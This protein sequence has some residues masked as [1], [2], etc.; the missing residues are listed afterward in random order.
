VEKPEELAAVVEPFTAKPTWASA[1][2]SSGLQSPVEEL[3]H[4]FA[5]V[6]QLLAA[7]HEPSPDVATKL[8]HQ[9]TTWAMSSQQMQAAFPDSSRT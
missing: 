4:W 5:T 8:A 9:L 6:F 1:W 3:A 2:A 7:G